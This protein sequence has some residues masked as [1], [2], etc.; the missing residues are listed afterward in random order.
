MQNL[1]LFINE[2]QSLFGVRASLENFDQYDK[3]KVFPLYAIW[4]LRK[5]SFLIFFLLV[6]HFGTQ[7]LYLCRKF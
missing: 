3:I 4:N 1:H 7:R 2:K 5:Y 6:L